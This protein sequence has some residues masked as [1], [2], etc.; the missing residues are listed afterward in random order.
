MACCGFVFALLFFFLRQYVLME[1]VASRL[2]AA[3]TH[4]APLETKFNYAAND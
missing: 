2:A 3:V 1:R 4:I